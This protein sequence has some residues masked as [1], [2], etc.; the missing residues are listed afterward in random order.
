MEKINGL[1]ENEVLNM[2]FDA[3]RELQEENKVLKEKNALLETHV[4]CL[5]SQ[6]DKL[7]DD[8]YNR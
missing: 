5:E 6:Y 4:D 8:Y 3:C 7:L 2:L 1:S